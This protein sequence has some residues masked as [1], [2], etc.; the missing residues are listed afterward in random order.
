MLYKVNPLLKPLDHL[1][2]LFLKNKKLEQTLK[3]SRFC[4]FFVHKTK[5]TDGLHEHNGCMVDH[6]WAVCSNFFSRLEVKIVSCVLYSRRP[7]QNISSF[8]SFKPIISGHFRHET[9]VTRN[10]YV[11]EIAISKSTI[12]LYLC[13]WIV[14]FLTWLC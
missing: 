11:M 14:Q 4:V 8:D 2:W 1:R 10:T 12:L 6:L 9:R 3:I 13:G 5:K 7:I